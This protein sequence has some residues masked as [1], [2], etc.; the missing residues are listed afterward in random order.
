[1]NTPTMHRPDC[2]HRHRRRSCLPILAVLLLLVALCAAADTPAPAAPPATAPAAPPPSPKAVALAFTAA[3][4]KG[5]APAAKA[6][7]PS[8]DDDRA[9]WVD[10]TVALTAGLK[11]LDAAALA[12]F[13]DGGKGLSQNQLHL[14]DAAKSIEQAQE[15]ID[16]DTATLVLPGQ[17]Q[18]LVSFKIVDGKWRLLAGPATTAEIPEQLA[19]CQRLLQAA[20]RTAEEITAGDH[21]SADSAAKTFAARVLEARLKQ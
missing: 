21:P 12:R 14:G 17:A 9:R 8:G 11:K 2:H 3:L 4:E 10:A 16:G 20:S 1:M 6:M 15:K 13:G 5:D 19:L 18:P 7:L